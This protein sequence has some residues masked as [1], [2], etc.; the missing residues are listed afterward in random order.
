MK[1]VIL[2]SIF[3]LYLAFHVGAGLYFQN[4]NKKSK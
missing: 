3:L 2:L 4:Q 1:D